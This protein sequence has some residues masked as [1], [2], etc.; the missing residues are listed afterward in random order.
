MKTK[1][2]RPAMVLI[3]ICTV[4][5]AATADTASDAVIKRKLLGYWNSGRH[6]HLFKSDG[7]HYADVLAAAMGDEGTPH[8][9]DIRSGLYYDDGTPYKIL[10]LNEKKFEFRSLDKNAT[11]DIWGRCSKQDIEQLKKCCSDWMKEHE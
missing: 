9:W 3:L 11:L 2:I 4:T 5:A 1:L 7:T 8:H 10:I 6:A